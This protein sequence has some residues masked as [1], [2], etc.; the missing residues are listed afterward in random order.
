M[1]RRLGLA[2]GLLAAWPAAAELPADRAVASDAPPEGLDPVVLARAREAHACAR[3]RGDLEGAA[4]P[5]HLAIID[6]AR[7]STDTRLWVLDVAAGRLLLASRVAHG[8]RTGE[9]TAAAF[10]NLPGSHQSSLG[11]FRTAETYLGKHGRSLRLDGLEPGINDLARERAI[12]VHGADY[13]TEDF[14]DRHGRLGRSW[15]C[16]AVAPDVVDPLLDALEGGALLV[17]HY[18]D[19]DW[20]QSSTYLSCD[21]R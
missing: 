3:A 15:G 5:D 10:S 14:V 19:A 20:L 6:F 1:S 17:A 9:L 13:A 16:P 2:L 18:P 11:V 8:Q 4:H 21:A 7:P 12:V